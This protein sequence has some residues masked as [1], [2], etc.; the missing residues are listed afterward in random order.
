[1]RKFKAH[2]QPWS[3]EGMVKEE[4]ENINRDRTEIEGC[5]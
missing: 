3:I 4:K 1:M 5:V 2:R